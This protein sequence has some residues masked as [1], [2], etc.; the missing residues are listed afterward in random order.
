MDDDNI[1]FVTT[2]IITVILF[3]ALTV[4]TIYI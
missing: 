1:V 2:L 3:A 4:M